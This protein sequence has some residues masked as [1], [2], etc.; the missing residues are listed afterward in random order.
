M[1]K[2][3]LVRIEEGATAT[4][5]AYGCAALLDAGLAQQV[6]EATLAEEG[7]DCGG[8]LA[9][10]IARK[11]ELLRHQLEAAGEYLDRV[12]DSLKRQRDRRQ[13]ATEE[14]Y[15]MVKSLRT[16]CRGAFEGSEG[17][18]FLGLSG[19]LPREPKE[20]YTLAGPLVR[21]VA[22]SDWRLPEQIL[23]SWKFERGGIGETMGKAYRELGESLAEVKESETRENIAK[24]AKRRA[25][26]AHNT[27][28][29]KSTRYL[30][31][32]LELAGLD[33]LAATVRPG[34]GRRGRPPKELAGASDDPPPL[35]S[36]DA[37]SPPAQLP[38]E[39][40]HPV[41][42]PPPDDVDADD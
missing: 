13:R 22:D 42:A 4:S 18:T 41:D 12:K 8:A 21:R 30:E 11:Q 24:V 38:A 27:F 31:A 1:P 17:D 9:V 28:L 15:D 23:K 36:A 3:T 33:D 39:A 20:L 37:G 14:L 5:V 25:A 2:K 26:K 40:A 10:R 6:G 7:L 34:V 32:A 29:D 19:S 35:P 16:L